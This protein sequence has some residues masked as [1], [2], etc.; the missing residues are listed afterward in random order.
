[1]ITGSG[2][3]I[4]EFGEVRREGSRFLAD[5]RFVQHGATTDLGEH[6]HVFDLGQVPLGQYTFV[7]RDAYGLVLIEEFW[8][9]T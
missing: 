6:E 3:D 1:M 2:G 7:L 5:V 4:L 9:T 8:L